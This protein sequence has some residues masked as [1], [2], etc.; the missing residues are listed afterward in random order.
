MAPTVPEETLNKIKTMKQRYKKRIDE[1]KSRIEQLLTKPA[2]ETTGTQIQQPIL[3][4]TQT[5]NKP[6]HPQTRPQAP[7]APQFHNLK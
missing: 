5:Q 2:T 4:M 7:P 3:T 6:P 1:Q